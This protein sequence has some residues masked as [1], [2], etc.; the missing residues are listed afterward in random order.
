MNPLIHSSLSHRVA[1]ICSILG[2]AL[3]S[4]KV[5]LLKMAYELGATAES[6]IALRMS[7]A[8]PFFIGMGLW[9]ERH[10]STRLTRRDIVLI[11]ATGVLGYY[12]ASYLD[13][14]GAAYVSAGMERILIYTYPGF[15]FAISVFVERTRIERQHYISL[16]CC[17]A[18]IVLMSL[19]ELRMVALADLL[20]GS[21]LILASAFAFACFIHVSRRHIRRIGALRFTAYAM[22]FACLV[23]IAQGF[24][25]VPEK[26]LMLPAGVIHLG[27]L[28]GIFCTA[29]PAALNNLALG[30]LQAHESA[31]FGCTGIVAVMALGY[32]V[33]GEPYG[34]DTLAGAMLTVIGI[35]YLSTP[36]LFKKRAGRSPIDKQ[37]AP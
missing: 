19:G 27:L 20:H 18:G 6:M 23:G 26:L 22:G 28:M 9:S 13:F 11:C 32:G 7:V 12:V 33:L 4:S 25:L 21:A 3:F 5:I 24:I 31:L 2:A 14:K 1:A 16:A 35:L 29:L 36:Q 8:L 34:I 10:A 37:D 17:Y 30:R 15:V